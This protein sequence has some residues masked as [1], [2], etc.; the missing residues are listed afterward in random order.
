MVLK[1]KKK[2]KIKDSKFTRHLKCRNDIDT[3]GVRAGCALTA[4]ED[5]SFNGDQVHDCKNISIKIYI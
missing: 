5:S 1:K 4:F 3:V 2:I